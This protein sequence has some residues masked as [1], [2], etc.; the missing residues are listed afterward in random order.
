MDFGPFDWWP[1]IV[2]L[3]GVPLLIREFK[4]DSLVREATLVSIRPGAQSA[5][6]WA[7]PQ[8]YRTEESPGYAD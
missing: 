1:D 2:H 8:A 3:G 5:S 6:L 4:F 7:L